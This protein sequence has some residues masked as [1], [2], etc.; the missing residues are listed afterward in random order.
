MPN[1]LLR[2]VRMP[3]AP[4]RQA[5]FLRLSW[6][7]YALTAALIVVLMAFWVWPVAAIFAAIFASLPLA[8]WLTM[9]QKREPRD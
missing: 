5:V 8:A 6:A 2:G 7:T 4:R 3:S 9:R 1:A